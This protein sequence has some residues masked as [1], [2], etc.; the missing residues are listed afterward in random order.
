MIPIVG[1]IITPASQLVV[2]AILVLFFWD[3][4]RRLSLIVDEATN[5]II[6]ETSFGKTSYIEVKERM[7]RMVA[8]FIATVGLIVVSYSFLPL[9]LPTFTITF[10]SIGIT[11]GIIILV[12]L[13]AIIGFTAVKF[14]INA[15]ALAGVRF[16]I[17]AYMM[18]GI[19][20]EHSGSFKRVLMN[21]SLIILVVVAYWVASQLIVL[22]LPQLVVAAQTVAA[23][24][25]VLLVWDIGRILY[26]GLESM[27]ERAVSKLG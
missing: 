2:A 27:A 4:G 13:L 12:M 22:V 20:S 7:L 10:P 9:I 16:E 11:V 25:V 3:M 5:K 14:A 18:P 15:F 6:S 19:T 8:Y 17:L 1:S 24:I 26:R 23:A 21:L